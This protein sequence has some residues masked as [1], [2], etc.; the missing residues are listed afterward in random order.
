MC[1]YLL[2]NLYVSTDAAESSTCER[3]FAY[4]HRKQ[5]MANLHDTG[6]HRCAYQLLHFPAYFDPLDLDYELLKSARLVNKA[7][8]WVSKVF[9][10]KLDFYCTA[11]ILLDLSLIDKTNN[12]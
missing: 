6:L 8:A 2:R 5:R 1:S 7:P 4:H 9:E 12:S 11:K 3:R 10:S